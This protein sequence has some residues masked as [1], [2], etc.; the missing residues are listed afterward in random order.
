MFKKITILMLI[1]ISAIYL[2][3]LSVELHKFHKLTKEAQSYISYCSEKYKYTKIPPIKYSP[4]NDGCYEKMYQLLLPELLIYKAK[5]KG[6]PLDIH[7][8]AQMY[9]VPYQ[10]IKDSDVILS[11][12][13]GDYDDIEFENN[14]LRLYKI[15]V[16]AFDCG[17]T[18]KDV[19][20][21]YNKIGSKNLHIQRECLNSDKYIDITHQISSKKIHSFGQ[22]IEELNLKNKKISL[23][24]GIPEVCEYIDDILKYK[25]LFSPLFIVDNTTLTKK[26]NKDFILVSRHHS[27]NIPKIEKR[28]IKY[29][30]S[31]T[32]KKITLVYVNKNILDNYYMPINQEDK[33]SK[34]IYNTKLP[35][36]K[37]DSIVVLY[38]K[39]KD[40]KHKFSSI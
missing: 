28:K 37:I 16:Y 40:I 31:M 2:V 38:K 34:Q 39:F 29:F 12:G 15:P 13:L 6:K 35:K 32:D 26:L 22:K 11:W 25:N 7:C 20:R 30:N 23:K 5:Y 24:L 19:K 14:V 18:D 17:I 33:I 4:G 21:Y 36:N 9:P 3:N 10:V 8:I 1:F 27:E